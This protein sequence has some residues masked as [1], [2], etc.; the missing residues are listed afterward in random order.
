MS[1]TVQLYA[2]ALYWAIPAEGRK[3][4]CNGCGP[5]GFGFLVPDTFYLLNISEAC[6]IHDFMYSTGLTIE[7][8]NE[9]DRAFLNNANRMI[10]AKTWFPPLRF[11]RK[12]RAL[13]YYMAVHL[14]GGDAYWAGKNDP[15][16]LGSVTV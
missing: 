13:K 4:L 15:N 12:R 2:P 10:D 11:L 1:K 7:D 5:K 8:K 9:A 3:E 14:F 16:E 6:N